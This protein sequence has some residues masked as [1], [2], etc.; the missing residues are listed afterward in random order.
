MQII[1]NDMKICKSI[2]K[3]CKNIQQYGKYA[4]ICKKYARYGDSAI[5]PKCQYCIVFFYKDNNKTKILKI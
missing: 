4:K 1:Y 2:K 5:Q 3:I